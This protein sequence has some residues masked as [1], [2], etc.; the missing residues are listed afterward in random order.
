MLFVLCCLKSW[1]VTEEKRLIIFIN[2]FVDSLADPKWKSVN[3]EEKQVSSHWL[4]LLTLEIINLLS[5]DAQILLFYFF[6]IKCWT[7]G[8]FFLKQFW[9]S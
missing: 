6:A 8:I 1:N 2:W 5:K 9:K 3:T 7:Y 4:R